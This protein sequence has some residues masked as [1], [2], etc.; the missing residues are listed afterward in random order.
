MY[1]YFEFLRATAKCQRVFDGTSVPSA[2]LIMIRSGSLTSKGVQ[3]E[4][5]SARLL[6]VSLSETPP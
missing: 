6:P 1:T 3:K 4:L 2:R 5:M